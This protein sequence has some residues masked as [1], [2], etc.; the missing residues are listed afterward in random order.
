[1]RTA[2]TRCARR[3]RSTNYLR[4]LRTAH[5]RA[6]GSTLSTSHSAFL[7]QSIPIRGYSSSS[8]W[9]DTTGSSILGVVSSVQY[10]VA[11][12]AGARAA[13]A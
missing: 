10:L 13:A 12:G 1:M 5:V 2:S 6:G 4:Y 9:P 8:Y 3:S 7:G 11:V